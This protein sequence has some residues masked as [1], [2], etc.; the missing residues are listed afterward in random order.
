MKGLIVEKIGASLD[1]D[2]NAVI[3]L[4]FKQVVE[5]IKKLDL[6][7]VVKPDQAALLNLD[8]ANAKNIKPTFMAFVTDIASIDDFFEEEA[9]STA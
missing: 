4:T 5:L 7:K 1:D 2:I 9:P 6:V 8:F 3:Y